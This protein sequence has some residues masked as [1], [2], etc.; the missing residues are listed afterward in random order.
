MFHSYISLP[1][2]SHKLK[3]HATSSKK[4]QDVSMQWAFGARLTR[5]QHVE[6]ETKTWLSVATTSLKFPHLY[7]HSTHCFGMFW[8]FHVFTKNTFPATRLGGMLA[9]KYVQRY[10]GKNKQNTIEYDIRSCSWGKACGFH[11]FY[12]YI[13]ISLRIPSPAWEDN[14]PL[15]SLS[16]QVHS[17]V[18]YER[19]LK[20]MEFLM[21]SKKHKIYLQLP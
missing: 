6:F 9:P 2:G 7:Q 16:W 10:V 15:G 4:H 8:Q 11:V 21:I 12:I 14:W 17:Q 13:Y 1:E 3:T 19:K 18:H 5:N 20:I